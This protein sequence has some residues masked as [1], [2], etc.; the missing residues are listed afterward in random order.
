MFLREVRVIQPYAYKVGSKQAG[1]KWSELA[2]HLNNYDGFKGMPR[3]QQSV[4]REHFNKLITEFKTKMRKEENSTG[5]SPAPLTEK[6]TLLDEIVELMESQPKEEK[7]QD[8]ERQKA[9]NV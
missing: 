3:D 4:R 5:I 9:L 6:E 1:Q 2:S 7:K 8:N